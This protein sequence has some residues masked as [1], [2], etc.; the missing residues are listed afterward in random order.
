M[1]AQ[2]LAF[3]LAYAASL[4]SCKNANHCAGNP[5]DDCRL[6]WDAPPIQIDAADTCSGNI[7]CKAPTTVCD[8]S[9][10]MMCVQCT[11]SDN[12]CPTAMP[13][14]ITNQCQKCTAHTQCPASN[15]CL[16]DG[17]C[18]DETQVAYVAMGGSGTACTKPTRA[19]RWTTG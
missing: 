9:G 13:I 16:L 15:V 19:G 11:T 7:D 14:C 6:M 10:T 5:L 17:S 1:S 4:A 3:T 8:L 2:R 12:P 18:A